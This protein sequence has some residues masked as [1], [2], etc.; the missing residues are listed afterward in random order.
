MNKM[1]TKAITAVLAASLMASAPLSM[2]EIRIGD[3]PAR[4]IAKE[5]T[6]R[7]KYVE[8]QCLPFA[9]AL[10]ARFRAAGIPSK[11]ICFNYETLSRPC[12]IFGEHRAF[13]SIYDRGGLTGVHAVVAYEDKGRT[14][15]MDNQSWQ[16]KWIHD[17]SPLGMARQFGG[18]DTLVA[19]ARV[20]DNARSSN[21]LAGR[22]RAAHL[23][24]AH[25]PSL[26]PQFIARSIGSPLRPKIAAA[27]LRHGFVGPIHRQPLRKEDLLHERSPGVC[28]IERRSLFRFSR[29]AFR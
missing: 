4:R 7:G 17:D 5:T 19:K 20:V 23:F 28:R 22:M 18:M 26:R 2:G 25:G 11:V 6:L 13:P 10:H 8:G 14:Y 1:S 15:L 9:L 3:T 21:V 27:G 16:P 29:L 24:R 12:E